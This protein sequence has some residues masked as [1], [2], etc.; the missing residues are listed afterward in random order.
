[1]ERVLIIEDD[2]VQLESLSRTLTAWGYQVIETDSVIKAMKYIHNEE[3][4]AA[5]ID[6]ILPD[7]P[8]IEALKMI[9]ETDALKEIPVFMMSAEVSTEVRIVVMSNGANDFLPKPIDPGE[10]SMKFQHALEL[11]KYKLEIQELNRKLEKDK[12]NLERYFSDDI[13]QKILSD[14]IGAEI[15]GTL[16]TATIMFFDIRGST[17][18]AEK[19]GPHAYADTI[20]SVFTD[21]MEIIF[22]HKGS[23]NELLGDGILATFGC[24]YPG[25]RD[26]ENAV[27]AAIAMRDHMKLLNSRRASEGKHEIGFGMGLATGR[28]FAGNIGSARMIKYAVMGDPVNT[29]ARIQSLTKK[30]PYSVIVDESTVLATPHREKFSPLPK[31][32]LRGKKQIVNLYGIGHA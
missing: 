31:L 10:L 27:A 8:G 24:P 4:D 29:A 20:N 28:I 3:I 12:K 17:T 7:H 14:D 19:I 9:R 15:G 18:L 11:T 25:E 23:V 16:V 30:F 5:L 21:V 6:L 1:M 32:M 2:P 13:V 26:A 22:D